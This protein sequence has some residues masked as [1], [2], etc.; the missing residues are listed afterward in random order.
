LGVN[1]IRALSM[2]AVQKAG[3]GHPGMPMGMAEAAFVLWTRH[4]KHNPRDPAWPDR[5]RFILSAGHGS[6]LLYSL[7]YLSG[8]PGMTLDGLKQF[9]QWGSRTPGHPEYGLT[10]GVEVTTGPLGQGF[11]AGVGMAIA[12]RVLARR[13]NREGHL[14]VDHYTYGIVSDGDLMEGVSAEAASL[15]GHLGLGKLIYLY[16]ANRIS[17]DGPTDLSFTEDVG[18]RFE[19]YGWQ[20]L[21]VDGHDMEAVDQALWEARAELDRPSL[22]IC[23]THIAYGSPN[24]QDTAAAHGEPLGEEEVR[25][26]KEA[27]GWPVEPPFF[28]P[29]EVVQFFKEKQKAWAALEA[30]WQA[31]FAAWC[32]AFPKLA[33]LWDLVMERRLPAGWDEGLPQFPAGNAMATRDAS[34][35]VLQ[36]LARKLPHLL[37]GSADLSLS[38]KT[39]LKAYP[40]LKKGDFSGRNIHFGVREHAMGGILNGL[41]LHGGVLPVG[42]T[43]LVFSDY[44]RPSLRLAALMELPIIYVFTHDSLFLGEDGPT[45][46]PVEHLASLRA[47]PNLT[48]IR[49][50]E[51]NEVREA[52]RVA[53]SHRQGPVALILTRQKVPVFDRTGLADPSHLARGGYILAEADRFPPDV[54]LIATGSEVALALE[55]QGLL[56]ERGV[57]GRVVALP[58]FELFEAQ[59]EAYREQV[60]PSGVPLR[61]AIEAGGR[62]GW[63]RYL[64]PQGVFIGMETFGASAP[65]PVLAERFGFTVQNIVE[66]V[67][68]L[69]ARSHGR[70]VSEVMRQPIKGRDRGEDLPGY[71]ELG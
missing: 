10:P 60:L 57:A 18:K 69:L 55:A 28:V 26:T 56:A 54:I 23:R 43:F 42:G 46:Q 1:A 36:V 5:D 8:A 29:E 62:L 41:A 59:D 37:T 3:S 33:E 71:G 51:A 32:T 58:S 70:V 67:L 15:A 20:V 27:L 2:D 13:F 39:Y 47:I 22:I 11:A 63:E 64:G 45:H 17:I 31:R 50:S 6:M 9:R 4:L 34:G 68:R 16:D 52:W 53:L 65:S 7:L 49:P 48:V 35:E 14:I 30:E 21:Q 19:A 25:L 61:V 40:P 66:Q 24:K 38:T 12:E 44:M